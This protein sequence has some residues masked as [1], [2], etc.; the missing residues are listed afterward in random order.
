MRKE[1]LLVSFVILLGSSGALKTPSKGLVRRHHRI[2]NNSR[3]FVTS[4]EASQQENIEKNAKGLLFI[5]KIEGDTSL[6]PWVS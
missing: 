6:Q 4:A 2:N 3:L 1:I 5:P